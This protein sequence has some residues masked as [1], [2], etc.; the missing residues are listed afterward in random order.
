MHS[1]E[2]SITP[3]KLQVNF[4]IGFICLFLHTEIRDSLMIHPYGLGQ[5]L[6]HS[7]PFQF[8]ELSTYFDNSEP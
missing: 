7:K 4:L 2:A 5:C 8:L 3:V 1:L 6:V